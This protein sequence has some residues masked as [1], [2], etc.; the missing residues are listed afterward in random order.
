MPKLKTNL[1]LEKI[2]QLDYFKK[3]LN[4]FKLF[5]N[6]PQINKNKMVQ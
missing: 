4:K 3:N 1:P 2:M 5:Q 6:G